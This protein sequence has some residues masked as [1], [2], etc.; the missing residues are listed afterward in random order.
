MRDC[1]NDGALTT[2]AGGPELLTDCDALLSLRD[3]LA[4]S[5]GL[6]WT[7]GLALHRWDG[8]TLGGNPRRVVKLELGGKGLAGQIPSGLGGLTGLRELD[9]SDNDLTGSIPSELGNLT[10]LTELRLN[11]NEL[12]GWIPT[13]LGSL[14]GLAVLD[15]SENNLTGNMPSELGSLN[16]LVKL[17]LEQNRFTGEI[18]SWLGDLQALEELYISQNGFTGCIPKELRNLTD[19]DLAV[20]GLPFCDVLLSGLSISPGTLTP[21]F[22]PYRTEYTADATASRTTFT[23]TNDNGATV[24]FLDVNSTA[25]ADADGASAGHQLDLAEGDTTIKVT[26][27]SQDQ[28]AHRTY[29][30]V[31]TLDD[32][33]G[34]Y[35]K[36]GDGAISKDE[37]ITAVIDYFNGIIT[38]EEAITVIIAYFSS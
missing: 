7:A 5:A 33:V 9:L 18:P 4:G 35:D 26:V 31:V 29:T 14:T 27:V 28:A 37:A 11:K 32:V 2:L 17:Y 8:V 36:D 12:T 22:D 3:D 6:N 25:L 16:Q 23:A 21:Q 15:L 38:K 30:I 13:E 34:R 10:A 19:H 24:G 20:A 1:S